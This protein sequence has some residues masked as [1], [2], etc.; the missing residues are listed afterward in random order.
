MSIMWRS[1]HGSHFLCVIKSCFS[2]WVELRMTFQKIFNFSPLISISPQRSTSSHPIVMI[3]ESSSGFKHSSLQYYAT[4]V[5]KRSNFTMCNLFCS[6][7]NHMIHSSQ[8]SFS[9][10]KRVFQLFLSQLPS[11]ARA[12]LDRV[13]LR[14]R[15]RFSQRQLQMLTRS[16]KLLFNL[17]SWDGWCVSEQWTRL[18]ILAVV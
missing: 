15:D 17:L 14:E 12:W 6:I 5:K 3:I 9:K 16:F 4:W 10:K 11:C 2:R 1:V 18:S 7:L 8:S 13:L